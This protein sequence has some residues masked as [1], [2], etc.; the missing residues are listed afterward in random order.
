[1]KLLAQVYTGT[2]V[3]HWSINIVR[4]DLVRWVLLSARESQ[5]DVTNTPFLLTSEF[6]P[7]D[8]SALNTYA[9][10]FV[11]VADACTGGIKE[12]DPPS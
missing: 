5:S 11:Q 1:M 4:N 7:R 6:Q 10:G 3:L 2:G 9:C 12:R 8:S